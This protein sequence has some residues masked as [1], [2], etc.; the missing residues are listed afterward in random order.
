[1]QDGAGLLYGNGALGAD[2]ADNLHPN[3]QGYDKMAEKWENDI[4]NAGVLPSC[5]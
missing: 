4:L 5:P 3:Q 2:M 1:M